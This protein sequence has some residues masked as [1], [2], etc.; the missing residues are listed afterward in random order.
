MK[1]LPM[2]LSLDAGM[3]SGI[4]RRAE[5]MG[6]TPADYTRNLIE[7]AFAARVGR[8]KR[9]PASDHELDTAVRAIFCLAGEF[10][11]RAIAKAT[12]FPESMVRDVLKGF[13]MVA[14]TLPGEGGKPVLRPFDKLTAQDEGAA[15]GPAPVRGWPD[16]LVA[17]VGRLWAEG[18]S[19]R[20][21]GEA[22]GKSRGA[23][24]MFAAKHRDICPKRGRA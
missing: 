3:H 12:G 21:I 6:R 9:L 19:A 8:E 16:A 5:T 11:V 10:D 15:M 14:R 20:R 23:V 7:A 1:N 22:I 2:T 13:A 18:R 4:C 24:E 17:E